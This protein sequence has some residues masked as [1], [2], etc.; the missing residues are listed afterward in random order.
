MPLLPEPLPLPRTRAA[1]LRTRIVARAI[2]SGGLH[3]S[4]DIAADW[5]SRTDTLW[6]SYAVGLTV[7]VWSGT[8]DGP[9]PAGPP[10]GGAFPPL[11][12]PIGVAIMA[13]RRGEA[14]EVVFSPLCTV[15]LPG[16][17]PGA[18]CLP[19][20]AGVIAIACLL[21]GNGAAASGEYHV[22]LALLP[23]EN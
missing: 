13:G 19:L 14:G 23:G 3:S 22:G 18:F 6:C 15:G 10:D 5:Q 9:T 16:G 17:E 11:P 4:P 2:E 12:G 7:A 8:G 1:R 20:P 21:M